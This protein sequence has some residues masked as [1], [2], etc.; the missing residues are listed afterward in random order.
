MRRKVTANERPRTLNPSRPVPTARKVYANTPP[1]HKSQT[2]NSFVSRGKTHPDAENRYTRGRRTCDSFSEKP[3]T[4]IRLPAALRISCESRSRAKKIARLSR[5][6]PG[7]QLPLYLFRR[8]LHHQRRKALRGDSGIVP[9]PSANRLNTLI[10]PPGNILSQKKQHADFLDI[11]L[12]A[13]CAARKNPF[14]PRWSSTSS[15]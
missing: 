10:Q 9:S 4:A 11:A 7:F 8:I 12:P 1:K 5:N 13:A 15:L 3:A 2:E 6:A 14:L